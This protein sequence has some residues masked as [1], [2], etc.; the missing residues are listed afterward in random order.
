MFSFVGQLDTEDYYLNGHLLDDDK[1]D[2]SLLTEYMPVP[3]PQEQKFI[4]GLIIEAGRHVLFPELY[5][6]KE[7]KDDGKLKF[8]EIKGQPEIEES[9]M[10]ERARRGGQDCP[11]HCPVYK[12]VCGSDGK[13]Y[14]SE[15][16]MRKENCG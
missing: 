15:C 13:V 3:S 5:V 9:Y 10:N 2:E 1:D 7:Q 4:E 16:Q 11:E 6:S 12:P 8:Y 14:E